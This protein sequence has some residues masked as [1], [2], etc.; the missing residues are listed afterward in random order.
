M[1]IIIII[2]GESIRRRNKQQS[3]GTCPNSNGEAHHVHFARRCN[4][5]PTK[6]TAGGLRVQGCR[7]LRESVAILD[8]T[9][10]IHHRQAHPI[11]A[12]WTCLSL[13]LGSPSCCAVCEP[14]PF[15]F[16]TPLITSP[17]LGH[18]FSCSRETSPPLLYYV[19]PYRFGWH[20][21]TSPCPQ[22][23]NHRARQRSLVALDNTQLHSLTSTWHTDPLKQVEDIARP[24]TANLRLRH[25]PQRQHIA[26]ARSLRA[27]IWNPAQPLLQLAAGPHPRLPPPWTAT[28]HITR[29]VSRAVLH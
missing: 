2:K 12:A 10:E 17:P 20:S 11:L 15:P 7:C 27:Q 9:E 22:Q 13:S 18:L 29:P 24:Q 28:T 14:F 23:Q 21:T 16:G 25:P 26:I 5:G 4:K 8:K 1:I 6:V 3:M 19:C